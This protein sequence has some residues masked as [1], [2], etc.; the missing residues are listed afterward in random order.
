MKCYRRRNLKLTFPF[1]I[2]LGVRLD[3]RRKGSN[4]RP[5][6]NSKQTI[7]QRSNATNNDDSVFLLDVLQLIV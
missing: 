5:H 3:G 6:L 7:K 4:V 1:L 2:V